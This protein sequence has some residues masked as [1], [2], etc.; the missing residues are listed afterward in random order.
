ME[1][2]SLEILEFDKIIDRVQEFAATIIGKEIISRLQPVDNLNYVKNK[3][4]EVSSARE[5]LEEYG[6]PPFG[7]IR[8][9]REII[10]K[11][12]KGIVLSVKEV[13]DVRS[14]LEGG[15]GIKKNIPGK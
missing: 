15:Q 6:R 9:L 13:M 2:S 3:L 7:G 5:I 8:D 11:A 12:D 14:T 4:R 10:E 1:E